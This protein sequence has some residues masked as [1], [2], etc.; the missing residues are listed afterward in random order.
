MRSSFAILSL[1]LAVV[2][3]VLLEAGSSSAQAPL[4]PRPTLAASLAGAMPPAQGVALSVDADKVT[5]P[6]DVLLPGTRPTVSEVAGA[7]GRVTQ[8]FGIVTAVAP[9]A[10]IVLNTAPGEPNIYAGMPALDALT[11]LCASLSDTQ[12]AALT[13][14]QGLPVTDLNTP[15]QHQ[16]FAALLSRDGKMIVRPDYAPGEKWDDKDKR[17]L[18]DALP[19]AHLRVGQTISFMLPAKDQPRSYYGS[20]APPPPPGA[21]RQY[22][23]DDRQDY[24][25]SSDSVYGALVRAEVPNVPKPGQLDF[26]LPSLA[27]SVPLAGLKTVGDLV[28]RIG[29]AA[30]TELYVDKRLE[31]KPLTLLGAASAPASNLLRALAFCLTGTHRQ[32]GPAYVLTDDI[33][34]VGTRHQ[35]WAEFEQQASDLRRRP[36]AEAGNTIFTRHSGHA[37]S[38]FGDPTAYSP[39]EEKANEFPM[40]GNRRDMLPELE[41]PFSKLT[42][43]QQE[44]ISRS[45]ENFN[46]NNKLQQATTEGTF[47][48]S[49]GLRFQLLVPGIDTPIDMNINGGS[50]DQ[51]FLWQV[52]REVSDA[53][54]AEFRAQQAKEHPEAPSALPPPAPLSAVFAA[55]KSVPR[56]AVLVHPRTAKDV[57][58]DINA[59]KTLGLN[60]LWVDVFSSGMAHIP[61]SALSPAR[62]LPKGEN[63]IL[64]EA[65]AKTKGTGIRVFPTLSLLFWGQSPPAQDA[66]RNILGETSAQAAARW[67]QRKSSLPEGQDM[68]EEYTTGGIIPDWDGVAVSPTAPEVRQALVALV[69]TLAR[70]GIAG[71]VWRDLDTPGYDPLSNVQDSSPLSLGYHEAMRLA[72]LRKYHADPLDIVPPGA[73]T[74]ANTDLPSFSSYSELSGQW[75]DFRRDQ[76]LDML[77]TLYAAANSSPARHMPLLLKQRRRGRGGN[78]GL[79]HHVY[80]PG[81]YGSWDNPRLPPPTLHSEGEDS[82]PGQPIQAVPDDTVQARLQSHA[83]VVPITSDQ[84][85]MMRQAF[86]V[87]Q[88]RTFFQKQ[89]MPGFVLDLDSSQDNTTPGADALITLAAQTA[90][91]LPARTSTG[92]K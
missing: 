37:L 26:S 55:L 32:V 81:W 52:P 76:S 72:F 69:Q 61:G 30:R 90:S 66:D 36:V 63:D 58:A 34:G 44:V 6:A 15:A 41:R 88:A 43:A 89:L 8:R 13:S 64:T 14:E 2:L 11:L 48:I 18:T 38:W 51:S 47:Q 19:Q 84:I 5:L 12:W 4:A 77:R 7:Y 46:Q 80:P 28:Y 85:T 50:V 16:L 3:G 23:V 82:T 70:P 45:V 57:D 49:P 68:Q 10:M 21:P 73:Y 79:G 78:D 39:E 42:P 29:R 17:D 9:P 53:R 65:L 22:K 31:D 40:I 75:R 86:S 24:G 1:W 67:Q 25:G 71:L 92:K 20:S 83:V 59:A 27:V 62:P 54:L 35:I 56:R 91:G 87:P 74:K 33:V 60:E